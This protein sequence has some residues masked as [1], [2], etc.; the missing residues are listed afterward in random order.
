MVCNDPNWAP[1]SHTGSANSTRH[2]VLVEHRR[3]PFWDV[4]AETP[5]HDSN[6][7]YLEICTFSRAFA[8]D[9][10]LYLH[11]I[12]GPQ[13]HYNFSPC[14]W[15]SFR[16]CC[17][18][19]TKSSSRSST[20]PSPSP[21]PKPPPTSA[22]F[23]AT[24]PKPSTLLLRSTRDARIRQ[25]RPPPAHPQALRRAPDPTHQMP[26]PNRDGSHGRRSLV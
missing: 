17:R 12:R 3:R 10:L 20:T 23:S 19:Q 24:R 26:S 9:F 4:T 14:L 25:M 13:S 6:S 2:S 5:R 22:T 16:S 15:R 1:S 7:T 8:S 18:S 21:S 11:L